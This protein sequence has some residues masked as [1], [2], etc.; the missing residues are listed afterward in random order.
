MNIGVIGTGVM[1]KN[2]VRCYS[3]MRGVDD[4]FVFDT[5][6]KQCLDVGKQ[7]EAM[8][9]DSMEELFGKVDA[10]SICVPTKFHAEVAKKAIEAGIHVLIEKPLA[11]DVEGAKSLAKSAKGSSKVV[12]VGHIERFNPVVPEIKKHLTPDTDYVSFRRHNPGSGR[13]TDADVIFDLMIHDIDIIWNYLFKDAKYSIKGANSVRNQHGNKIVDALASFGNT[14]VGVSASKV[15]SK[16]IREIIVEDEEKT[17]VAD[18]TSQEMYI[19]RTAS[20]NEAVNAKYIQENVVEKVSIARVEPLAVELQSFLDA[21][22]GKK[23]FEVSVDDAVRALM[24]CDE[25]S[26]LL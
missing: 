14:M 22:K 1:G 26:G 5:N 10:A 18:M 6:R 17:I 7:Y 8:P 9:C 23:K 24:V 2:H 15:A 4:I 3:R 20:R 13:I 11:Q 25:I 12:A 16:R 19:Y 21:A